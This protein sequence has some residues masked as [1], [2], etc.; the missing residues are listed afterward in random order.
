MTCTL[1]RQYTGV[2]HTRHYRVAGPINDIRA[3]A[4][5]IPGDKVDTDGETVQA[6][7]HVSADGT[8]YADPDDAPAGDPPAHAAVVE[9]GAETVRVSALRFPDLATAEDRLPAI[10]DDVLASVPVTVD[11]DAGV[12]TPGLHVVH[13]VLS[14]SDMIASVPHAESVADYHGVDEVGQVTIGRHQV[15]GDQ[16]YFYHHDG[17]DGRVQVVVSQHSL[18]LNAEEPLVAL[19]DGTYLVDAFVADLATTVADHTPTDDAI[20]DY[21]ESVGIDPST[22][23]PAIAR[24]GSDAERVLAAALPRLYE[25]SR[26]FAPDAPTADLVGDGLSG[27]A[28]AAIVA[29]LVGSLATVLP[30]TAAG[31]ERFVTAHPDHAPVPATPDGIGR[32]R[33]FTDS[34]LGEAASAAD[35]VL[36]R[37]IDYAEINPTPA[38]GQVWELPAEDGS[39]R[40]EVAERHPTVT[41]DEDALRQLAAAG[42]GEDEF[43]DLFWRTADGWLGTTDDGDQLLLLADSFAAGELVSADE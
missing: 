18:A 28:Y 26:L 31:H 8:I 37:G 21:C 36:D 17:I 27:T 25:P 34:P 14:L 3:L 1:P 30:T 24:Y 11:G 32:A 15:P 29:G 4:E 35:G 10:R 33:G 41:L 16:V 42:V 12:K 6:A 38:S 9:I 43:E 20:V 39:V 40:V 13:P 2:D 19:D 5:S 7:R 23:A 22:F